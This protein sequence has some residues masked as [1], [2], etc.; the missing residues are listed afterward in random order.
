MTT[1]PERHSF[2]PISAGHGVLACLR[3][4]SRLVR[5]L[6]L[7]FASFH[8]SF[9]IPKTNQCDHANPHS[10]MASSASLSLDLAPEIHMSRC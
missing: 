1:C 2:R 6:S 4:L 10:R 5:S 9:F 8:P 7:A 3:L